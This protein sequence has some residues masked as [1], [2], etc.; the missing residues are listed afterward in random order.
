MRAKSR[1]IQGGISGKIRSNLQKATDVINTLIFKVAS[2][3]DSAKLKIDNKALKDEIE[4][5]K[6]EEILR[7][8]EM[9]EM[10]HDE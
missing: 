1:N 8:K 6:L 10:S 7:K 3:G 4:K 5:L 9:D 2:T